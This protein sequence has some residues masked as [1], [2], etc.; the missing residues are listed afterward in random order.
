[1]RVRSSR[2]CRLLDTW[3]LNRQAQF[4]SRLSAFHEGLSS[5]GY[6]E[7]RNVL[8]EY[9]WANSKSDRLPALAAELVR[10]HVNVIVAP[11][12]ILAALAAKA[13]TTTIPI[14]FE[15][16]V[17]PVSAGLV[18]SL[19]RPGGNITGITSLN[20]EVGPKRLQLLHELVPG[21]KSFGVLLNPSNPVLVGVT[22]NEL[23][24]AS[25]AL[26][27]QLHILNAS[28]EAEITDA[29]AKLDQLRVG[30]LL[31]A[32]D[33][34]FSTRSQELAALALKHALPAILQAREF[35]RSGGLVS[36]GGD[37]GE[38]HKQAG[39]YT[40][41]VLRG[42]RPADLPVQ[43]ITKVFLILNLKTAKAL[44]LQVPLPLLG[45]ADE[46]IE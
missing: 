12:S 5:A 17:D 2:R 1:V 38:S 34:F 31:I 23:K 32:S 41:R 36:F 13:A 30:G 14:V 46:V 29:F 39:I 40:G 3:E 43:Q 4:A 25:Q 24:D 35:A 22:M 44:G 11:G 33:P 8:I 20:V 45:R 7:G 6:D 9:R 10:N 26:G 19:N 42:E 15:T 27:L 16:G 37:I 21:A 18:A 28:N